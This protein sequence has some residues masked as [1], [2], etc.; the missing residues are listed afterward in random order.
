MVP[1]RRHAKISRRGYTQKTTHNAE[2]IYQFQ[3]MWQEAIVATFKSAFRISIQL[4][5]ASET[6][7]IYALS[8]SYGK[9]SPLS[10]FC[11]LYFHYIIIFTS[12][13]L[14]CFLV[15]FP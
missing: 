2:I 3:T 11:V 9:K 6:Y 7:T 12:L 4:L 15:F 1:K 14:K 8:S 5:V 13:P 10:F